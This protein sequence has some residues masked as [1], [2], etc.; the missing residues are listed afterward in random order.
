MRDGQVKGSDFQV[1]TG[2]NR[3]KKL[4]SPTQFDM[5]IYQVALQLF[6]K[7]WDGLPVRGIGITLSQLEKAE[8]QQLSLF[9]DP[10]EKIRLNE[11]MDVIY[12]KYGPTAIIRASSLMKAGQARIRAGKIGGHDKGE[13]L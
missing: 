7:H 13:G 1:R 3:Q 5:D 9:D 2:F 4:A 6:R 8:I 12:Q 11:T 10:L